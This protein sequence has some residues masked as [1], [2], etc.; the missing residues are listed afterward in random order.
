MENINTW[1]NTTYSLTK[2]WLVDNWQ[3]I[4]GAVL[5]V[6]LFALLRKYVVKYV[7]K[8]IRRWTADNDSSYQTIVDAVEAPLRMLVLVLGI[9]L[10]LRLL[11]LSTA[12]DAFILKIF[13]SVLILI[14]GWAFYRGSSSESIISQKVRERLDVDDIVSPVLSKLVRFIVIALLVVM[15]ANEWGYDINGFIAGL[16]L[17]GLA[18]AL[19]AQDALS[20]MFGG[21]VIIMEKPFS[22]GD[23]IAT[24]NVEG[25]VE[26]ITFRSTLIRGFDQALITV[27]NST[28]ANQHITNYTRRGKRRINYHLRLSYETSAEQMKTCVDHIKQMLTEHP[29][30]HPETILVSFENFSESSLDIM[31]YCYTNTTVWSEYLEIRQNVNLKI[32]KILEELNL[33]IG[34]PSRTIYWEDKDNL[35]KS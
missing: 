17:G 4:L 33:K 22:I 7:F 16:G 6:L 32:M 27:P 20:N 15:I 35:P 23:W 8:W 19:A 31:I 3:S 1:L 25:T 14:I 28:L 12:A 34:L 21:L 9:F 30:I 10:A 5:I 18:V 11:P 26:D 2:Y 24:P 29:G 13:R